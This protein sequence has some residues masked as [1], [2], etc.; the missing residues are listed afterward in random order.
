MDKVSRETPVVFVVEGKNDASKLKQFYPEVKTI[1]TNGS[2]VSK[3][4]LQ[5]LSTLSEKCRIV[6]LLDPDGP[7]EKIRKT[8]FEAIP[9][10]EHVFVPRKQAI[11]NNKKKVGIEHMNKQDL[12][13][14]LKNI[15]KTGVSGDLSRVQLF[16]LGLIGG[17]KSVQIR[18]F[19]CD[20]L[21]IGKANGK[22]LLNKLNMFGV[23]FEK[24][25]DI[26]RSYY[27]R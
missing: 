17:K 18:D 20:S 26:V 7:G 10:A 12:D 3:E 11:S 16:D 13:I 19:V 5:E 9:S 15:Q 21:H 22:T 24:L 8:I 27:D 1:I 2:A 4:L 14:A 6:L 25:S 23:S